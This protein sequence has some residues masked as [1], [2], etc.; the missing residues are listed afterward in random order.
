M[1]LPQ[2]CR[3][4]FVIILLAVLARLLVALY[5]G[6]EPARALDE[7]SYSALAGR[8]GQGY[9]YSFAAAWY[10]FT[11]AGA[12]TAHWSFLYTAFLAGV[13]ALFGYAPLAA[14]L[15]Q[16]VL[17]GILLPWLVY[18]L[19]R[20]VFAQRPNL[21]LVAAAFSAGY[22][23][24]ILYAAQ[25]MTE[26]FY[27]VALLWSLERGIA[28]VGNREQGSGIREEH[29]WRWST[30]VV[31]G[32]SLGVATLLRQSVMPWVVVL[33]VWLLVQ[34]PAG[35]ARADRPRSWLRRV[36]AL[37]VAG[38]V[39]MLF[40]LPFTLRNYF[41]Y[42]DFLLLNSNAGY[43]MYSAQHPMHGTDFQA[44][45]AAP[46]P[47]DLRS[48][49]LN[50]PQWDRELLR[51]GIGFILA[52]P[53]RYLQLSASRV[54]DYFEFWPTETTVLHNAGRLLS[55]TLFL[56]VA[57]AG[58][59]LAARQAWR[60]SSGWLALVSH[61]VSLLSLFILFYS[62]LHLF[63]W[64][65]PRYRLP[66]DAVAMPFAALL[67]CEAWA[68]WQQR[69]RSA[70]GRPGNTLSSRHPVAGSVVPEGSRHRGDTHV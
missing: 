4:L 54:L 49:D 67:I 55:F 45:A 61:P 9:G 14:R 69:R 68:A 32:I 46:L 66:V 48:M 20:R 2:H 7:Y 11:P 5:L 65:M 57:L 39:M 8:L 18:R 47:D 58:F 38:A 41:V 70:A 26:T 29:G 23:Y 25:L 36:G 15:L 43:A 53:V 24:F 40:I 6:N 22:A 64:A 35:P 21:A 63:T 62:L 3:P 10:P 30:A 52:D 1:L 34:A 44:F 16:A 51:R 19:A 28:L 31:L 12:P 13:Y 27:I 42:G 50:E 17:G 59:V 56:P 60:A 37:V 33:F